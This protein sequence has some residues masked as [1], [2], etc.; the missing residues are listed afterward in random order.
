MER[1]KAIDFLSLPEP[2]QLDLVLSIQSMRIEGLKTAKM[3][4]IRKTKEGK[5]KPAKKARAKKSTAQATTDKALK[6]L[7]KLSPMQLEAIQKLLN[8]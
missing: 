3:P 1:I 7:A 2:S 5:E 4:K 8:Q 6:A